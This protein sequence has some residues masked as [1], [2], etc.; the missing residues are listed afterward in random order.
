MD[1]V[2]F[3]WMAHGYKHKVYSH[4]HRIWFLGAVRPAW[5]KTQVLRSLGPSSVGWA[6]H[7]PIT[8]CGPLHEVRLVSLVSLVDFLQGLQG[9]DCMDWILNFLNRD[10]IGAITMGFV[11]AP[12]QD[13]AQQLHSL[14]AQK[15]CVLVRFCVHWLQRC[16]HLAPLMTMI[17]AWKKKPWCGYGG[18][19]WK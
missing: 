17:G 12:P 11:A 8:G 2:L 3:R 16:L 15:S 13:H 6:S 9:L 18:N 7:R 5:W 4:W 14:L 19:W 10:V 1:V